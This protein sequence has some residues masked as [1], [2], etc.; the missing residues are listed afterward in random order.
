MTHSALALKGHVSTNDLKGLIAGLSRPEAYPHA[1]DRIECVETHI[2]YVLLAG[3]HA[4]KLKKSLDLGFLDFSTLDKRRFYC[5]EELRLNRRLAP[6]LY[7]DVLPVIGTAQHPRMGAVADS[8]DKVLEWALHMRRFPQEALLDR[9][10]LTPEMVDR[11]AERLAAFHR[12]LPRAPLDSLYGTQGAVLKPMLENIKEVRSRVRRRGGEMRLERIE[13][14]TRARWLE[15]GP[16]LEARRLEGR[17]R[18]CHGDMHRGNIAWLDG[19][20]LIF[21]ALEFD[22]ALRWIDTASELAFLLMDLEEAGEQAAARRLL[23]RYLELGGDY[24]ALQVLDLYKVYRAMVRAKVSAIRQGQAD[25][26]PRENGAGRVGGSSYLDLA[27]SYTRPRRPRLLITHGLSGSGKSQ[28]GRRLLESLPLI[29]LRSDVERKRLFGLEPDARTTGTLDCGIY[30]PQATEWTYERL[31]RLA[32]MIL[33]SGYD[34]LVD[35]TFL[36]RPR[37]RLFQHLAEIQDAGFAILALEASIETLRRRLV[38]RLEEGCDASEASLI[39]LERQLETVD[40][41]DDSEAVSAVR[42]D[43]SHPPALEDILAAI[44]SRTGI[45][46]DA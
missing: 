27:E 3:E 46:C 31:Y 19:S 10:S 32:A 14:W 11:L 44:A 1:V 20:A 38:D 12:G 28:F 29:H 41:L 18:E 15:L 13:A 37:R 35:A 4:Y 23:N 7:L 6:G 34:V 5:E 43:S 42:I 40:C 24:G 2:S 33:A 45:G 22:P 25:L 8:S 17:V 39:V 9:Q 26:S 16:I 30:F 21:D 36:R